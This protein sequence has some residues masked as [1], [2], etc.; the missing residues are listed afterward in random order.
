[1]VMV[2]NVFF[3]I[4]LTLKAYTTTEVIFSEHIEHTDFEFGKLFT[5]DLMMSIFY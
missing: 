2:I 4:V 3:L 1:M 5:I